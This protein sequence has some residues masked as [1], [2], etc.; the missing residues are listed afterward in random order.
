MKNS[1]LIRD[2]IQYLIDYLMDMGFRENCNKKGTLDVPRFVYITSL[3][4][5]KWKVN[6]YYCPDYTKVTLKIDKTLYYTNKENYLLIIDSD[7]NSFLSNPPDTF[8]FICNEENGISEID[9]ILEN[10]INFKD[11]YRNLK[12]N[13]L[14]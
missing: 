6:L 4:K 2:N 8:W 1:L 10:N 13:K 3:I 5:D 11:H 14:I 7:F 9:K 12:I